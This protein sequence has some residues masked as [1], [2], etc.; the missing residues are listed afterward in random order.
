[1]FCFSRLL[2]VP[3]RSAPLRAVADLDG[4]EGSEA[5][6]LHQY[7]RLD[8]TDYGIGDGDTP[9]TLLHSLLALHKKGG[10][11]HLVL[12]ENGIKAGGV[13]TMGPALLGPELHT[14]DLSHNPLQIAGAQAW[15][16][17]LHDPIHYSQIRGAGALTAL[18]M[19]S[20]RLGESGAVALV[21]GL[22]ENSQSLASLSIRRNGIAERGAQ[23]VGRLVAEL[24]TLQVRLL[25]ERLLLN[26]C[27]AP[28]QRLLT[29]SC[30]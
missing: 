28:A 8:L 20:C 6:S 14:L 16:Q 3:L 21:D 29:L 12:R 9:A 23:A 11:R 2:S 27:F 4:A 10:L 30:C 25:A 17:V 26:G 7:G 5:D 13:K 18:L 19:D 15:G 24:F 1:M 22:V